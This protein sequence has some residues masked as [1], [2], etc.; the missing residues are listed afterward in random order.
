MELAIR[1]MRATMPADEKHL[2]KRRKASSM[3]HIDSMPVSRVEWVHRDTLRANDYNPNNVFGPEMQLLKTSLLED[4]WT[5]PLVAR[6]DGEI[7]DGFHRWILSKDPQIYALTDGLVPVVR[8]GNV[9]RAHQVASTIRYNRA[10]G[11]HHVLKMSDIV[12]NLKD[13]QKLE[14]AEIARI[15]GMEL[16]EVD[17]L[18]ER[19]NMLKRAGKKEFGKGWKPK[20]EST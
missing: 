2:I 7:V 16:L 14:D 20:S 9:D 19:G 6:D 3:P 18:Y 5:L 17:L 11:V 1:V 13:T 10:R 4:G 8:L 12:R 15:L